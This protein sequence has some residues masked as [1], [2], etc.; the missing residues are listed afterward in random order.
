M[1]SYTHKAYNICDLNTVNG[2]T[3][4]AYTIYT[5]ILSK[6]EHTR[7]CMLMAVSYHY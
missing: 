6:P 7:T 2:Y 5:L 4:A 1:V 3:N